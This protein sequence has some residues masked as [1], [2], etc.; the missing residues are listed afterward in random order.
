MNKG[1]PK[2]QSMEVG[3]QRTSSN[4][5]TRMLPIDSIYKPLLK[6]CQIMVNEKAGFS[7]MGNGHLSSETCIETKLRGWC[8]MKEVSF[9][10]EW[11]NILF[12][13]SVL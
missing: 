6:S 8:I 7:L 4:D 10:L 9:S 11:N 2:V 3:L 1:N 5:N 12:Q 13:E